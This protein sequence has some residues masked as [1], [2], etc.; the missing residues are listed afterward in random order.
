MSFKLIKK[1]AFQRR[2]IKKHMILLDF[3]QDKFLHLLT[4]FFD[5]RFSLKGGTLLYKLYNSGR[6]S[7]DVDLTSPIRLETS[8]VLRQLEKEGYTIEIQ[9]KRRTERAAFERYLF[10]REGL[11]ETTLSVEIIQTDVNGEVMEFNSPYPPIPIFHLRTMPL[12]DVLHHKLNAI[13]QREKPR[14]VYDVYI[15]V[16]KY[17]I[18]ASIQKTD[19]L[20]KALHHI[21]TS[22]SSLE[23]IVTAKLP[24][25][26]HVRKTILNEVREH[27]NEEDP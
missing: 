14:D 27:D 21:K 26:E 7:F 3:V 15:I 12:E 17:G 22:W 19:A 25:F 5:Q 6:F 4:R 2:L 1:Y 10:E 13:I 11:G 24:S 18:P 8:K 9:K 16:K 23:E 20:K